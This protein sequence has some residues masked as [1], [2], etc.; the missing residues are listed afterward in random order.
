MKNLKTYF[1]IGLVITCCTISTLVEAQIPVTYPPDSLPAKDNDLL[2]LQQL[3]DVKVTVA[4]EKELTVKESPAVVTLITAE[5]L[6]NSGARDF[7]DV[8][9]LVPGFDFGLDVDNVIGL[10]VRGNWGHESKVL[11]TIDGQA[12][13]ETSYGNLQF[14]QHYPIDNIDRIEIIRGPGSVIYGGSAALAVINI[15]T[16]SGKELNGGNLKFSYGQLERH[17]GRINASG[18]IGKQFGNGLN[19]SGSFSY[20]KGIMSDRLIPIDSINY[21][22]YADSSNIINAYANLGLKYKGLDVRYIY[23]NYIVNVTERSLNFN[24][25]S[26]LIGLQYVW[27][28]NPNFSITPRI[29]FKNQKPWTSSNELAGDTTYY[30]NVN[31][32]RYSGRLLMD[33][34]PWKVFNVLAGA[35]FFQDNSKLLTKEPY[36]TFTNGNQTVHYINVAGF[37][38]GTVKTKKITGVL[39]FRYNWHNLFDPVLVPRAS[40]NGTFGFFHTKLLYSKAFRA[41]TIYN[42]EVN[43]GIKPETVDVAEFELGFTIAK[44]V[45]W[46]ANLYYMK[47]KNPIAYF[48]N[49]IVENYYNF[50]QSGTFGIE[51]DIKYK[52]NFGFINLSYSFYDILKNTVP[53]YQFMDTTIMAFPAFAKHQFKANASIK[54]IPNFYFNPSGI[55]YSTRYYYN[56]DGTDATLPPCFLLN[57]FINYNNIFTKGLTAGVG[58]YD[59]LGVNFQFPQAYNSG[60]RP[61]PGPGREIILKLSYQFNWKS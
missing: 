53:I 10:G 33:Y 18:S 24:F 46:N 57:A 40:I 11:L 15:I 54:I 17:Y 34:Q 27:K 31:N 59:I 44:K 28:V 20:N 43:P 23:D 50:S 60:Y 45:Q 47:V 14:A 8:I 1:L 9:R 13:Q 36:M 41:P 3:M 37:L 48:Q 21:I 4:S 6:K 19:L 2:S 29:N 51:T 30:T 7:M 52:D 38:Q 55:F 16:K 5:E 22:D 58:V 25:E 61:L 35:E 42:L 12:M 49:G 26:H 32:T 39:G 56:I